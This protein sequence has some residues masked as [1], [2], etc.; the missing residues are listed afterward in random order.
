MKAGF[1]ELWNFL[2]AGFELDYITRTGA[3]QNDPRSTNYYYTISFRPGFTFKLNDKNH[4]GFNLVYENSFERNT[5]KNSNSAVNQH[6]FVMK[7][8]G[9]YSEGVV[10]NDLD[11]FYYKGNKIGGAI[12]Y[13]YDS[14]GCFGALLDVKYNYKAED[15]YQTPTKPQRMGSI[16]QNAASANLQLMFDCERYANKVELDYNYKST[17]GIEFLQVLDKTYEVQQWVTLEQYI[18]SNYSFKA[19]SLKYDFFAKSE[20]GYSWRAGA[21]VQYSDKYDE[22]Y[23]PASELK[24][25]NMYVSLFAKKNFALSPKSTLLFGLNLGYS[26]NL[27]GYYNYSGSREDSP[28]VKEMYANDIAFLTSDYMRLGGELTF[29]TIVAKKSSLFISAACQYLNPDNELFK[30]RT[31]VNL[32]I[33]LNF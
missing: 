10:G 14:D 33:G 26:F 32:S 4:I 12:Q 15:A 11:P 9:N 24:A 13:G 18:R 23:L 8:L 6:V 16:V 3:K 20:R 27:D 22:Y 30:D 2:R 31:N 29:S 19:F 5:F 28:V 17:D 21:D 25:E 1:P 7:G